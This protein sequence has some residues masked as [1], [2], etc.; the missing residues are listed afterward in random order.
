MFRGVIFL[1]AVL[2]WLVSSFFLWVLK[3]WV[4]QSAFSGNLFCNFNKFVMATPCCR[5][6]VIWWTCSKWAILTLLRFNIEFYLEGPR[7][8]S[9]RSLIL[10]HILNRG[11]VEFDLEWPKCTTWQSQLSSCWFKNGFSKLHYYLLYCLVTYLRTLVFI[12][13]RFDYPWCNASCL[14]F[15]VA[16]VE[17]MML[18]PTNAGR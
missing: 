18:L 1:A 10:T 7:K 12:F 13:K 4:N 14:D 3:F 5:I 8:A 15:D 17:P 2:V 6:D 9:G 16:N 11:I